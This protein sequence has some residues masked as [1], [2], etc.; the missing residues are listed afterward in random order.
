M[1]DFKKT[2]IQKGLEK[3]L[4]QST[5]EEKLQIF[6]VIGHTIKQYSFGTR[7]DDAN[8]YLKIATNFQQEIPVSRED[9]QFG[10]RVYNELQKRMKTYAMPLNPDM[11]FIVQK[12]RQEAKIIGRIRGDE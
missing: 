8:L 1:I 2:T 5:E 3:L 4:P 7:D 9:K 6:S 11:T 12:Q 10:E